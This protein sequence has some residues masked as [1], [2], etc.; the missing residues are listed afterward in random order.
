M[1][2]DN[3]SSNYEGTLLS[4]LLALKSSKK[5]QKWYRLVVLH[6][7]LHIS[8]CINSDLYFFL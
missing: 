7:E 3:L 8:V 4:V 5:E 6:N 2:T 1:K